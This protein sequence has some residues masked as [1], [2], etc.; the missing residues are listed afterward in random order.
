MDFLAVWL[1]ET[2]VC[3][4]LA[5]MWLNHTYDY[6]KDANLNQRCSSTDPGYIQRLVNFLFLF[7]GLQP[8]WPLT[9]EINFIFR[10]LVVFSLFE[11]CW[12]LWCDEQFVEHGDGETHS[13]CSEPYAMPCI[14]CVAAMWLADKLCVLTSIW[15][16]FL[17][18]LLARVYQ[19]TCSVNASDILG[20]CR[21]IKE[22]KTQPRLTQNIYSFTL[23]MLLCP[24]SRKDSVRGNRSAAAS[25]CWIK[26]K[27]G[28]EM[29]AED[30]PPEAR[31]SPS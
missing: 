23:L 7:C 9:P 11:P 17:T 15:T 2:D 28:L 8:V 21:F 18:K 16:L 29:V 12:W 3:G 19:I 25:H 13:P 4:T 22:K 10:S 30:E 20:K 6:F 26:N 31:T 14:C 1:Q 24:G 5:S 27:G